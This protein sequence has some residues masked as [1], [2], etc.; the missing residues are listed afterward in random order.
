M[1][2]F[3]PLSLSGKEFKKSLTQEIKGPILIQNIMV[4][5]K[6]YLIPVSSQNYISFNLPDLNTNSK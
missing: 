4:T 5:Q 6:C 3:I 2:K 1:S